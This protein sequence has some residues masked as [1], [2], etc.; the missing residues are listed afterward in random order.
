[1]RRPRY[2]PSNTLLGRIC[3]S[4]YLDLSLTGAGINSKPFRWPPVDKRESMTRTLRRTK[5]T[6]HQDKHEQYVRPEH[7]EE[8]RV[9]KQAEAPDHPQPSTSTP[10]VIGCKTKYTEQRASS[11]EGVPLMS[12]M[13]VPIVEEPLSDCGSAKTERPVPVSSASDA[14]PH[15]RPTA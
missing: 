3:I 2:D 8:V 4:C 11:H 14:S 5:R 7:A 13:P 15:A 12:P 1:M 10:D 9:Q 6:R